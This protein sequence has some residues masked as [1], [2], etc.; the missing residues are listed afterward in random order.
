M[1]WEPLHLSP[2][3]VPAGLG[4][5]RAPERN[6]LVNRLRCVCSSA[7]TGRMPQRVE[8]YRLN[9]ERCFEAGKQFNDPE[10]KRT[11][12]AMAHGWMMLAVQRVKNIAAGNAPTS[13]SPDDTEPK[14]LSPP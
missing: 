8:Q 2:V 13:P 5:L 4:F 1:T 11:M 12:F 10:A 6:G 7:G 14:R 3:G 9:A